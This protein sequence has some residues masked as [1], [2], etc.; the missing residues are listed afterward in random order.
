MNA[1]TTDAASRS[2]G[3]HLPDLFYAV[4][5]SA[6]DIATGE[7]VTFASSTCALRIPHLLSVALTLLAL[8]LIA[9]RDQF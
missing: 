3:P 2:H 9:V 7:D 4:R 6:K 5:Q 1:K 8:F